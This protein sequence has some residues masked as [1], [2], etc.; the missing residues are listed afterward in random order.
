MTRA[1]N[2]ERG[3]IPLVEDGAIDLC[4]DGVTRF[5]LRPSHEAI[6]AI[7][8]K[9]GKAAIALM[10][11]AT[12]GE[13]STTEAAI[14]TTELVQAWGRAVD[15]NVAKNVDV[16]R[17]GELIHEFGLMKVMMRLAM[18][19]GLAVTGGCKAD[20]T[21]KPGEAMPPM[22]KMIDTLIGGSPGSPGRRSAGRRKH[23]GRRPP[24]SS[25]PRSKS[26]KR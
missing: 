8:K 17:I 21:T 13:M 15:D 20:G 7:E 1:A 6:L 10:A 5:V 2:E 16:G 12:D 23:S 14:I 11:A 26:G 22:G 18:A 4:L 25:G 19:L 3:E 24:A 9:T